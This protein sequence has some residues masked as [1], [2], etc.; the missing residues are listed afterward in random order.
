MATAR[1]WITGREAE[2][3]LDYEGASAEFALLGITPLLYRSLL[4]V[5]P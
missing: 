3:I 1:F 5:M 4:V 2:R